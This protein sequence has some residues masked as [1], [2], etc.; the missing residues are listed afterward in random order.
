MTISTPK[1][2]KL[3]SYAIGARV[4]YVNR[5]F[6]TIKG[7]I[8]GAELNDDCCLEYAISG[9]AWFS[10][11]EIVGQY[12][13]A[14]AKT[15]AEIRAFLKNEESEDESEEDEEDSEDEEDEEPAPKRKGK[16]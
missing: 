3:V 15:F 12:A 5:T 4:I 2:T 13:P 7:I 16:K 10:P 11:E 14:S 6:G 1:T 8:T 9:C